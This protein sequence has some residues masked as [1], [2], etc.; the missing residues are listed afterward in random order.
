MKLDKKR[1]KLSSMQL[2]RAMIQENA[3]KQEAV[4]RLTA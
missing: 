2:D 3:K 4:K 1:A